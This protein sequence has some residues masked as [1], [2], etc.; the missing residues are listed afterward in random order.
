M[1][2]EEILKENDGKK[3]DICLMNPPYQQRHTNDPIHLQFVDKCLDI[4]D[5]QI[6]VFP[7]TFITNVNNKCNDKY[8]E[9]INKYLK[10]VEEVDSKLFINTAIPNVGIY[11]FNKYKNDNNIDIK[12]I[13]GNIKTIQ[14]LQSISKF[15]NEIEDNIYKF[16]TSNNAQTILA[17]QGLLN[18]T[19]DTDIKLFNKLNKIKQY[20]NENKNAAA[21][22]CNE[23]NGRMNATYFSSR[24]GQIFDTYD[25]L[26]NW[27]KS[28]KPAYNV[29][30]FKSKE[31]AENCKNA[32]KRS[33]LRLLLYRLQDD[34]HMYAKKCYSHIPNIDWSDDRVNTDEGLLE[35]C[36]CPKDKCKEYAE[37]CKKIIDEV[38]KK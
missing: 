35:V 7:F 20:F 21:L 14:S 1:K 25:D 3:F 13:D 31:Y 19:E 32:M 2:N 11:E 38:D 28:V 22:I 27:F 15:K 30:L 8:K 34:Q 29:L 36:G 10:G 4:A 23:A 24:V 12:T 26:F 17:A 37:Y 18:K 6:S 16:I 33:V 9:K 5:I